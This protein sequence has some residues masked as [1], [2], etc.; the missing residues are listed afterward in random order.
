M[1]SFLT[2]LLLVALLAAGC[3]DDGEETAPDE[4]GQGDTEEPTP[5]PEPEPEV[6]E[7]E[8]E[9]EPEPGPV[10]FRFSV[11][12]VTGGGLV[13]VDNTCDGANA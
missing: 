5:D 13:P 12:G 8:P 7:P 6:D 2:G 4:P 1:R 9:P 3:G 10:A 11:D